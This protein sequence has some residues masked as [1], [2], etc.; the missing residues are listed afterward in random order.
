MVSGEGFLCRHPVAGNSTVGEEGKWQC[1]D[2]GA[3]I[4]VLHRAWAFL[5]PQHLT[6]MFVH[7]S[8]LGSAAACRVSL[9]RCWCFPGP[10]W[11][12]VLFLPLPSLAIE[13]ALLVVFSSFECTKDFHSFLH[14]WSVR[15]LRQHRCSFHLSF[16]KAFPGSSVGCSVC[17]P[18]M[19]GSTAPNH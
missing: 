16:P 3:G 18:M 10:G 14:T 11:H 17:E 4:A 5:G 9:S 13:I 6:V 12:P 1:L 19:G 8:S 7:W 2:G 15:V